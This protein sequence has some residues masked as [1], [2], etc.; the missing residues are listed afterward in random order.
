MY[1]FK[2][3]ICKGAIQAKTNTVM[4]EKVERF[5]EDKYKS[6]VRAQNFFLVIAFYINNL[7][8]SVKNHVN[9]GRNKQQ[10]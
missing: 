4:A 9:V 5:F 1:E 2:R 3:D 6:M 8:D 10:L 7:N